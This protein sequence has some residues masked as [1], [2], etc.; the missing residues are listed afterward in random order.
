[1]IRFSQ[2]LGLL[3]SIAFSLTILWAVIDAAIRPQRAFEA[4]GH[5]KGY[6]VGGLAG[7]LAVGLFAVRIPL[8][9]I[10][11]IVAAIVYLVEYRPKLR[12]IG[13]GNRGGGW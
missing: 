12:E 7:G 3:V 2:G 8:V 11:A 9:G 13:R 1:M 10:L 4:I 6:W 5:K